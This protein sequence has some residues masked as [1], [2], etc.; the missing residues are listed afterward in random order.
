L[1]IIVTRRRKPK[2]ADTRTID[3]AIDGSMRACE[4]RRRVSRN[5]PISSSDRLA[6]MPSNQTGPVA[7][8]VKSRIADDDGAAT[9]AVAAGA[10]GVDTG[11]KDTSTAEPLPDA[12]VDIAGMLHDGVSRPTIGVAAAQKSADSRIQ[13]RTA[14]DRRRSA[15]AASM[16]SVRI[17]DV[18]TRTAISVITPLPSSPS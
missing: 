5:M 17:S 12:A 6:A 1:R 14:A 16:P 9:V 2:S 8:L 4:D 13:W 15:N 10:G 7:A 18:L 3:S 11:L